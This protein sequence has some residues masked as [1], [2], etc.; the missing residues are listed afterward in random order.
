M[1]LRLIVESLVVVATIA[2]GAALVFRRRDSLKRVSM[3]SGPVQVA[4]VF[5]N[6]A[7]SPC[8]DP[9]CSPLESRHGH[10]RLR[11]EFPFEVAD[12]ESTTITTYSPIVPDMVALRW[13]EQLNQP[14]ENGVPLEVRYLPAYSPTSESTNGKSVSV[15]AIQFSTRMDGKDGR[16]ALAA[17][18][19]H[20]SALG[21]EFNYDPDVRL[22]GYGLQV[23]VT[24]WSHL[25]ED[26]TEK[27]FF[28]AYRV[29]EVLA[30]L[31]ELS[32]VLTLP[33]SPGQALPDR[34]PFWRPWFR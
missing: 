15:R 19:A 24:F 18:V 27:D 30:R 23:T 11:A 20:V 13:T 7:K 29:R 21:Q 10:G 9:N 31:K 4:F 34:I 32:A 28:V 2:L 6:P 33:T 3:K 26:L 17:L 16:R 5:D 1:D 14:L 22:M 8:P 12:C 25:R